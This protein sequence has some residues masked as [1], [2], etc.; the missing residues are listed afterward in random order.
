MGGWR[1]ST[2]RVIVPLDSREEL[3]LDTSVGRQWD[4]LLS[5]QVLENDVWLAQEE[6]V[7]Q[8]VSHLLNIDLVEVMLVERALEAA[9]A[10]EDLE[11]LPLRIPDLDV[12]VL[13]SSENGG[14]GDLLCS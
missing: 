10:L 14:L 12:R 13:A 4:R 1:F 11:D 9:Q 6:L 8:Q 7:P 3:A 5:L 2:D